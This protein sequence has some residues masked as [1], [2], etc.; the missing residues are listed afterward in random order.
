MNCYLCG[1]ENPEGGTHCS[2]CGEGLVDKSFSWKRAILAPLLLLIFLPIAY[3][4]VAGTVGGI[5]AATSQYDSH[6]APIFLIL[7]VP[8][9]VISFLLLWAA[10]R[11]LRK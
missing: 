3:C 2:S 5:Q 1:A 8:G 11:I 4:S 10:I 9:L 6:Y 7:S